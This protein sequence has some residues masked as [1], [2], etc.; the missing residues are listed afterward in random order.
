MSS[1]KAIVKAGIGGGRRAYAVISRRLRAFTRDLANLSK[2]LYTGML[3]RRIVDWLI[4][5]IS[6]KPGGGYKDLEKGAL[7]DDDAPSKTGVKIEYIPS[8]PIAFPLRRRMRVKKWK[9]SEL[10]PD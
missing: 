7:E 4:R 3:T 8:I 9:S 6:L 5:P 2:M 10:L 1:N